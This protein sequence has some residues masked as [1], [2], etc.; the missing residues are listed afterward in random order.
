VFRSVLRGF[1]AFRQGYPPLVGL[2]LLPL[3]AVPVCAATPAKPDSAI[4]DAAIRDALK[5]WGVPGASVAVVRNGEV[6]Y[7]KGH[8]VREAGSDR[9]MT[10]DT[11]FPLASCTKAF[12][13]TVMAML[14]DEGKMSWDDPVRKHLD[15]FH[16]SDP[17]ADRDVRLRDLVTHRTGV[18]SHDLLWYRSPLKQEE[19][20]RR[21][22]LLPL[23]QP[24][25][26]TF[27]Y[28]STMF[29]AA[30]LAAGAAAKTTWADLVRQRL[31]VPLEMTGASLTTT[32]AE[33]TA[34]RA[35]PHRPG[36][37]GK[38]DVI[39]WYPQETPDPAGSLNA[40]ARDLT[41]W[42]IFHLDE[43]RYRGKRL[44][45]AEA[46]HETHTPQI[47]LPADGINRDLNPETH[48]SS[49]GMAWRIQ[50]YRRTLLLSHAG[51]IDGFRAQIILLPREKVGIALLCNMNQSRINLALGNTLID[52][53]LGLPKRDWN[54]Y[55]LDVV[56][57]ERAEA[58]ARIKKRLGQR[59]PNAK[60]S[61]PL[62]AYVG[63]YEHPAYGQ[64]RVTAEDGSL[65]LRWSSFRW[66]LE[67][68]Q[69]DTFLVREDAF[70][71]ADVTF[72]TEAAKVVSMNIGLPLGV[73][74]KKK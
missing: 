12:T 49:Y 69:H 56:K 68:V 50:D 3:F 35:M 2:L 28:Q 42:L 62:A 17:L 15:W 74:F 1:T 14:V 33:K 36:S 72:S 39:A 54:A 30:G 25:R 52:L 43:G 31:L 20:V 46:L 67:H 27:Q 34:D 10:P 71:E 63:S 29:T 41:K 58:A 19:L 70:G 66:P 32:E 40:S 53:F 24:F 44:V 22:G 9:P 38:P 18:R 47:V 57:K 45:S 59:D 21:V 23:D 11:I 7:L 65:V 64:A 5:A 55:F 73:T 48:Q 26:T 13:T 6:I 8:G 4:V 51:A 16:L 60:P 61:L 37:D